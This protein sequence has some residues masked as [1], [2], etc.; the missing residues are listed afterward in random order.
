MAT[1]TTYSPHA[2][3]AEAQQYWA[4]HH[5]FKV[6]ENVP[7]QAKYY[8]L[9]AFPYPSGDLHMGH[10][11]N[12]VLGDAIARYFRMCGR[13][14]LHAMGWDALGLPAEN[15]ALKQQVAPAQWTY[16]N[17]Q[18]M[19][20]QLKQLGLSYDWDRE[21]ATCK[22]DYYR[23]EQWLFTQL[24]AKGLA[25]R[26]T[27][28]VNWDPVDQTVLANEQVIDGRGWRSGAVVERREI[29]QWF[30]KISDYADELLQD[31]DTLSEWPE[32]VKTMQ[33]NWIG[34][35]EGTLIYFNISNG[36]NQDAQKTRNAYE[37]PAI[38][39]LEVF[40]TRVDTLM[41]V[42]YLAIAPQHPLAEQ[43]AMRDPAIQQ[44]IVNCSKLSVAEATI[45]TQAK[46]GMD[47]GLKAQ[48]PIT[49]ERLPIWIANFVV[50]DYGTGAVMAVPAHDARDFEF[51]Q[52]YQLAIRPVIEAVI[53]DIRLL[54]KPEFCP[55]SRRLTDKERNLLGVNEYRS[56]PNNEEVGQ[57]A[58]FRKQSIHD[59]TKSAYT[60][61]GVL[62]HSNQFTGLS[63]EVAQKTITDYLIAQKKGERST[64]YRLRDWCISRQRY[65]GV[66]IPIIHCDQCGTVAVPEKDLPVIL[67]EAVTLIG[68]QSPLHQPEFYQTSCPKCGQA[69][70]RETDTFDTFVESSWYYAR[71][72]CPDNTEQM[73]D[74]RAAYW[75][76]VDQYIIGV[77]HAVLHLLY[78]R[79]FY[80]LLLDGGVLKNDTTVQKTSSSIKISNREPFTRLLTQGMVLKGGIKM[81]KS[82]ANVVNPN[83]LIQQYGADTVRLFI[84][85][86]AP[87]EQSLEWSDSGVA[88][89]YR[90]LKRLW[91][92]VTTHRTMLSSAVQS[93]PI[94]P[95]AVQ[96]LRRQ[97]HEALQLAHQ[98][99]TRYQ[100][101]TVVSTC[102]K[103]L[104][105]LQNAVTNALA[106]TTPEAERIQ[107]M[108]TIQEGTHILLR[109]LA[110]L[111]PHIT[112]VLWQQL[113]FKEAI[114]DAALPTVDNQALQTAQIQVVVQINGKRRDMLVL[115]ANTPI[116]RIQSTALQS[117]AVQRHLGEQTV[118][119]IIVVPAKGTA[120]MLLNLVTSN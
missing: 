88:G 109:L 31:L 14:V 58:Q 64:Q 9:C 106:I 3:E 39:S 42:S 8:C 4:I 70:R 82:K 7:K 100:F 46:Q 67:P 1:S 78:A 26:K 77:E 117:P 66:P 13:K 35:S 108:G 24:F 104:N 55:N 2:I 32:A 120:P 113:G 36:S 23:W 83:D 79:F 93:L 99:Y 50:M 12:Y 81:S 19:R 40:S 63:S 33:R 28:W 54:S 47:T 75:L 102:M 91:H 41:G 89:A 16:A 115:A 116:E 18:R 60:G 84:L 94:N 38:N 52:R 74:D 92:F 21:L 110:P 37:H 73:L 10:V 6:Q 49:G 69:A 97:I 62:L 57:K 68:G 107:W 29:P 105:Q 98:D 51:A 76:P 90:F 114:L 48:H 53:D 20:E 101:N 111:V 87:P 17:I 95:I 112:H 43:I 27:S 59:Y 103:L 44:F 61:P 118:Q 86:A 72:A 119:N 25:Y 34:R 22:P 96:S 30:L 15:A 85:F 65:W 56:Q 80:K 5:C 71:F 45:A 11:R